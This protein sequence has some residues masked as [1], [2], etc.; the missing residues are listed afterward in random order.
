MDV[1]YRRCCGLDVHKDSVSACVLVA[2]P[3]GRR[4]KE[5][6]RFG[7]MT[8]D[9]LE[10]LDWLL[11]LRVTH[12]AME[13]TGVYW[14]PVWNI[15]EGHVEVLLANAQHIKVVPGRK[16][17]T[18]DCEWIADL[19]QHGLLRGSFVPPEP[20]RDLRDLTR[21][22]AIL[23][24]ETT[25]VANRIQKVLE[26]ANV[27]LGSVASD[28]L[29]V[30]GRAMLEAIVEGEQDPTRLAEMARHRL[31]KKI[32]ELC[33]ALEGRIRDHHRFLLKQLLDHLKFLES[34]ISEVERQVEKCMG[35]FEK[36]VTLWITIPGVDVVTAWSLVAE[37][38]ADMAQF[39][40]AQH[41]ASWAGLCPGNNESAGK[42]KSGKTRKGSL[43]L[44]RALSQAAWAAS[45]TK[46]TY[47]AARYRRLAARRGAKRAIIA[48][49]HNILLIAYWLLQTGRPYQDLGAD[50]F[51]RI[52][53]EGLKRYLVRRLERMGHQVVL[54]P[55]PAT[56]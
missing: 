10:L 24:Q 16:T 48:I 43:W 36:A 18:Q 21:Y 6:R 22:R 17:D 30:S 34:K 40:S 46:A 45:R 19:L 52:N 15:L 28:V 7:T 42:R 38:G 53:A 3:P 14:K 35:P 51:D 26:D 13:S 50:Y 32:P 47:L 25:D 31:R 23:S 41:L 39:P 11:E 1:I 33:V 29:G 20:V 9:L 56:P 44:R 49:A 4:R 37:T 55:A 8:R 5:L 27:K 54:T 2:E 12:A